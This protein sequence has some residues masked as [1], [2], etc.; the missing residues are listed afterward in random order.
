MLK[1]E[2]YLFI[3]LSKKKLID[4]NESAFVARCTADYDN[5]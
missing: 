3:I 4:S 5:S 1:I 2:K